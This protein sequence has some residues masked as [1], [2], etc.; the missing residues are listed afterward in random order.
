VTPIEARLGDVLYGQERGTGALIEHEKGGTKARLSPFPQPNPWEDVPAAVQTPMLT[1][2]RTLWMELD[3]M[4]APTDPDPEPRGQGPF[5]GAGTG[6]DDVELN[7]PPP[8]IELLTSSMA[9][10]L[11]VVKPLPDKHN[12]KDETQG[13]DTGTLDFIHNMSSVGAT[14]TG[15]DVRDVVSTADYFVSHVVGAYEEDDS[16]Q[17]H[18]DYDPNGSYFLVGYA[19]GMMHDEAAFIF[20]E[21]IRDVAANYVGAVNE[22]TLRER[23]V[24]HETAHRFLG[25]HGSPGADERVM[26]VSTCV[27]GT[28][29]QNGLS[30][31]QIKLIQEKGYPTERAEN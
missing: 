29:A 11:I 5:D 28:P 2:W 24:L 26:S 31:R 10:A 22:D 18:G 21:T 12:V 20:F 4:V 19:Y 23:V 14:N 25:P 7:P 9:E 27:T 3:D 16:G 30:A 6:N 13:D 8:P 15:R 1:V 17:Y